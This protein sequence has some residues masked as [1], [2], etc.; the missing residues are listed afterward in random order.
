MTSWRSK[1]VGAVASMAL[2]GASAAFAAQ[3][4][5]NTSQKGSLLMFPAIDVR[6]GFQTVIRLANDN[7]AAVNVK[8]YY[9]NESKA[10]ADFQ[11]TL[12]KKQPVVWNAETGEGDPINVTPFP[13]GVQDI[14]F[15]NP[16]RGELVCFAV[17]GA[18]SQQISFNHLSAT[19]TIYDLS[20][21]TAY[22]YNSWNFVA[23][24][25]NAANGPIHGTAGRLELTGA[26]T[27]EVYDAC[28]AYNIVHFA[29]TGTQ[30]G[31]IE[32][33]NTEVSVSS[34]LQDL[35][36]DYTP[37]WTKLEVTVWNANEVRFTGAYECADSTHSFPLT[38]IDRLPG[39][40]SAAV[41]RTETAQLMLNGVASTQ[42]G[43]YL[44]TG[45]VTESTSFVAV[46]A[47]Q[48]TIATLAEQLVGEPAVAGTTTNTAGVGL[49][50]F[51]LWDP[52]DDAVPERY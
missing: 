18:G 13:A 19:A 32:Y 40:T 24:N 33:H 7:N 50:G 1:V 3:N 43:P 17:N 9:M 48:V 36:Q 15:G 26:A 22:E 14:I 51:V 11:F 38:G 34:C 10:R 44:P 47:S 12:T 31:P 49:P 16:H 6:P 28:P 27:G 4:V 23:R 45:A 30:V 25:A 35:R 52:A 46:A 29:P 8:C 39:N 2:V 5:A 41:L 42:C 20:Q 21:G 37:H